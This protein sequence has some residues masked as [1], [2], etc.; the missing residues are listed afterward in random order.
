MTAERS[1]GEYVRRSRRTV[2]LLLVL[3]MVPPVDRKRRWR[4]SG[5]AKL[6]VDHTE[7]DAHRAVDVSSSWPVTTAL[8]S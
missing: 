3:M 6:V 4:E 5:V 7:A 8:R 2:T 1:T